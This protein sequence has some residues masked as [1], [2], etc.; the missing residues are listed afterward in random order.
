M[1]ATGASVTV[2]E[3]R[4]LWTG[5]DRW[6]DAKPG[7]VRER[8]AHR[9]LTASPKIS[10]RWHGKRQINTRDHDSGRAGDRD[11]T[12]EQ[13]LIPET[14]RNHQ[15]RRSL[16]HDL[17]IRVNGNIGCVWAQ[18]SVDSRRAQHA[19]VGHGMLKRP[20]LVASKIVSCGLAT[21]ENTSSSIRFRSMFRGNHAELFS[22]RDC[23][24]Q[25][26]NAPHKDTGAHF[27]DVRLPASCA[28]QTTTDTCGDE[29][30]ATSSILRC[31]LEVRCV[32]R[33][34]QPLVREVIE[35]SAT[36]SFGLAQ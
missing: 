10:R 15:R 21:D 7:S 35:V 17:V 28:T 23:D 27:L 34:A 11:Y 24:T 30:G 3:P 19:M 9:T 4:H 12:P 8:H 32:P 26:A 36:C 29:L 1:Q 13:T 31:V 16:L 33:V 2:T 14:V 18:D 25:S 22:D 20:L 6:R 5:A